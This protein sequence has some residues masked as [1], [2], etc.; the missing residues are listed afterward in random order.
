[1]PRSRFAPVY[2][3]LPTYDRGSPGSMTLQTAGRFVRS[4]G[5]PIETPGLAVPDM[6]QS[7]TVLRKR[8]KRAPT[9]QAGAGGGVPPRSTGLTS[10]VLGSVEGGRVVAGRRASVVSPRAPHRG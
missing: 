10:I 2:A 5:Y 9:D 3:L 6:G 1:M 4:D 7:S 8:A